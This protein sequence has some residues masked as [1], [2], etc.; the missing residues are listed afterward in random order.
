MQLF[1][2]IEIFGPALLIG[3]TLVISDLHLGIEQSFRDNGL[4]LPMSSFS[5]IKTQITDLLKKVK[6]ARV[7]INGD[8][9]HEFGKISHSEWRDTEELLRLILSH[10]GLLLIKGNHDAALGPI[11]DRMGI[12]LADHYLLGSIYICHGH[13]VPDDDDFQRA[14]TIVIGHEHPAVVLREHGR[15][16]KF[17]CY[18]KG[19]MRDK[20]ILVMPAFSGGGSDIAG[21]R[22]S[23]I[24]SGMDDFDVFIIEKGNVVHF[25]HYPTHGA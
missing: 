23:P 13:R 21:P 20:D 25:P 16:E 22:L 6:P 24:I 7:I 2:G 4:L 9:K 12:L 8:L 11:A 19:R 5:G 14:T 17:Q 10:A 1:L 15:S 3:D 18:L